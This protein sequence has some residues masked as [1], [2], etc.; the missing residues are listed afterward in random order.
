MTIR[1][2]PGGPVVRTWRFHCQGPS[3]IP[4]WGTNITQLRSPAKKKK[5]KEVYDSQIK[6]I[7]YKCFKMKSKCFPF[8][9]PTCSLVRKLHTFCFSPAN[10]INQCFPMLLNKALRKSFLMVK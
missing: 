9:R 3:S 7:L 1:K 6:S 5:N 4:G 10:V 8:P 2:F